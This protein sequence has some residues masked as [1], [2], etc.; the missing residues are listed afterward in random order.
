M[1]FRDHIDRALGLSNDELTAELRQ[2]ELDERDL[3][4]RRSALLAAADAKNVPA[5]DGHAS[6]MGWLVAN[7]NCSRGDAIRARQMATMMNHLHDIADQ[8]AAGTIGSAQARLFA[9]ALSKTASGPLLATIDRTALITSAQ[10]H[11]FDDFR[12]TLRRWEALADIDTK[13]RDDA[14]NHDGRNGRVS[15]TPF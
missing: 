3:N 8:F 13:K 7:T 10:Q 4:T 1:K 2:L 15:E 9:T 11:S 5:D 12:T 6:T 14:A